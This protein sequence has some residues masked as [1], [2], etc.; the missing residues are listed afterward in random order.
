MDFANVEDVL[1]AWLH[2]ELGVR[3]VTE[4]PNP[5][6]P[7]LLQIVRGGGH[8]EDFGID[9][10]M[11]DITAFGTTR[12]NA[13]TLAEQVRTLLREGLQGT[14]LTGFVVGR[15]DTLTAPAWRPYDDI[16]VR[17]YGAVY[18]LILHRQ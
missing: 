6:V 18:Q 4:T 7:P 3:V 5:L 17:R 14:K 2:T 12:D 8:D 11:L 16:T 1:G 15:V 9:V 10:V 13:S